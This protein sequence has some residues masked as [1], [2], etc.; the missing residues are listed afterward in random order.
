MTDKS[1]AAVRAFVEKWAPEAFLPE[2]DE[3]LRQKMLADLT[4]LISEHYYPKEFVEWLV[5]NSLPNDNELL[6]RTN[7]TKTEYMTYDEAF[8]Y[9]KENE[10]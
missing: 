2:G 1:A 8:N 7:L 6:I 4:A 10:Q 5:K 3:R 9:W